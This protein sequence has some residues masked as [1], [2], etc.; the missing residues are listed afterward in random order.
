MSARLKLATKLHYALHGE[1]TVFLPQTRPNEVT[2]VRQMSRTLT[3]IFLIIILSALPATAALF[4]PGPESISPPPANPA[5]VLRQR[6]VGIDWA[7]IESLPDAVLQ[8]N[9]FGDVELAVVCDGLSD[10]PGESRILNGHLADRTSGRVSMVF[11]GHRLSATI[12]TPEVTYK[13]RP[14][15]DIWHVVREIQ[16]DENAASVWA[17]AATS[18]ERTVWTLTNQERTENGLSGLSL[19][20][21]LVASA[22][23]HSAD[24]AAQNYFSHTG[25]DGSSPGDR[26]D[27]TGY[28]ANSWGENIAAGYATPDA[29]VDGWMNSAG[30][31]ANIL[32]D[33]FCDIGVGY[34]YDGE[35]TYGHYWT[36]NFGRQAGVSDCPAVSDDSGGDSG[37]SDD[38]SGDDGSDADGDSESDSDDGGCFIRGVSDLSTY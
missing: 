12:R 17:A 24:M 9:L 3:W 36:Q 7:A 4:S 32:G 10:G 1:H 37:G 23:A 2:Q 5:L 6:V 19:N 16:V 38:S 34:A 27:A 21:D 30:H 22:R 29:V 8:L 13:V 14:M 26:I 35:S 18:D 28:D 33:S 15:D 20:G 11:D 31:R 25:L